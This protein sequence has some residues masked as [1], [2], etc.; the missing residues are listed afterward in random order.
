MT[1]SADIVTAISP[2]LPLGGEDGLLDPVLI[3]FDLS[4]HSWDVTT[5]APNPEAHDA[6]L[7]PLTILFA[8][9]RATSITLCQKKLGV[10]IGTST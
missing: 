9:K 7:V 10:T 4:V 3:I 2:C 5:A 6:D 8:N 1:S